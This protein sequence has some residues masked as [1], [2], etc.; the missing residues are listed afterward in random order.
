MHGYFELVIVGLKKK[1][2]INHYL[3]SIFHALVGVM[4]IKISL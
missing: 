3:G 4:K 1:Q 2:P